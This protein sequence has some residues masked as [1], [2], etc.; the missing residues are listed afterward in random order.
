MNPTLISGA[1]VI[2]G[3]DQPD[4]ESLP[5]RLVNVEM[6][7]RGLCAV[8]VSEWRPTEEERAALLDGASVYLTVVGKRHPPVMLTVD[9]PS[10]S[11]ER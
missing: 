2:L 10:S 9:A 11:S 7:H 5:I 3:E 4:V 1:G 6:A 8:M